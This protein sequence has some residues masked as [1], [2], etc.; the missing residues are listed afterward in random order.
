MQE[1]RMSLGSFMD[2]FH[3]LTVVNPFNHRESVWN[4]SVV[5]EIA[6]FIH[7]IRLSNIHSLKPR[8][9]NGTLALIWLTALADKH[10]VCITGVAMPTQTK[11]MNKTE[12][13][14]WYKRHGFAV[15][16]SGDIRYTPAGRK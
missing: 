9:G 5:F 16:P 8:E 1:T 6:I 10:D 4:D 7:A 11:R 14:A 3:D 15:T 2:E 13:K 12:L